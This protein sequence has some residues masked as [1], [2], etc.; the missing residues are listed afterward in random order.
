[1]LT[2][3]DIISNPIL[4]ESDKFNDKYSTNKNFNLTEKEISDLREN[5]HKFDTNGDGDIDVVELA[6]ILDIIGEAYDQNSLKEL[7]KTAD[8]DGDGKMSFEE[9]VGLVVHSRE[10]SSIF[11]RYIK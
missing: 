8:K 9:F 7:I 4:T 5:F 6:K 3:P 11:P 10:V 1:M 2:T